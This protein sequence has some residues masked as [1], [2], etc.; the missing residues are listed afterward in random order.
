MLAAPGG[1]TVPFLIHSAW[2]PAADPAPERERL[3][4]ADDLDDDRLATLPDD[5]AETVRA[6]ARGL[7]DERAAGPPAAVPAGG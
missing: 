4:F 2:A 5:L 3:R 1:A 6:V 7:D